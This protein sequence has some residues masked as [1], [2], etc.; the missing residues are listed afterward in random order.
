VT[1]S[2]A[3]DDGVGGI[4][5]R[6]AGYADEDLRI[7]VHMPE[8]TSMTEAMVFGLQD[9]GQYWFVVEARD[10]FGNV[11]EP[12][13]VATTTMDASAPRVTVDMPGF[14]GPSD[15]A[16]TGTVSDATSG[17]AS[18]EASSDGG[19]T[20]VAADLEEGAWSVDLD[21]V[22]GSRVLLR[23]TDDVGNVLMDHATAVV[24]TD[25][26]EVGITLPSDGST[27][28]GAVTILGSVEDAHLVS[29]MVEYQ[30]QGDAAW[31]VVQPETATTGVSGTLA[32]WVTSG[33][34]GGDYTLRVTAEDAVDLT[35][36]AAVSVTLKGAKLSIGPTD[37]SFSDTHPLPDDK[38]TVMVTV[39]NTGDS[40]AEGVTVTV[41]DNGKAVGEESGVTVP[42]HGTATVV[43]SVKATEGAQEFTARATSDL[44]DTGD[45][46][47]GKPLKTIEREGALENVGGILG[48]VALIIALLALVLVLMM[49][50]GDKGGEE[51]VE[52]PQEQIILDP[53]VDEPVLL[54]GPPQGL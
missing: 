30:K 52:E 13:A 42:A 27:V 41:Y 43:V 10:V 50:M 45:M 4:T 39:R 17:V 31:N 21:V 29:Y 35:A 44:Y 5:Y 23:A 32:T 14:F 38:V 51:P 36:F 7:P 48:L 26:P 1:W 24:D 49:K 12:S 11:G 18:V 6:L 54:E 22:S 9:G 33:L 46:E 47:T 15:G 28:S 3:T 37:I 40:P 8:W 20:W 19:E 2:A 25:A 16:V 53:I 34:S